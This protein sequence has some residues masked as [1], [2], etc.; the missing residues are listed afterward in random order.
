[1]FD[2]GPEKLLLILAVAFIVLGPKELPTAAR[3]VGSALRRLR[4]LQEDFRAELHT[5]TTLHTSG[6][7]RSP[8]NTDGDEAD[9]GDL[10]RGPS[11]F[12]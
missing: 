12:T 10:R 9:D 2:I 6:D 1:M 4:A 5:F 7:T 8:S 11:S 3:S